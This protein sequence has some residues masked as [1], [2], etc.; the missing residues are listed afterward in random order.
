[1]SESQ[2]AKAPMRVLQEAKRVLLV[3]HGQGTHNRPSWSGSPY[4]TVDPRLTEVGLTQAKALAADA[5]LTGVDLIVVSPLAR[6]VQTAAAA[7]DLEKGA[8]SGARVVLLPLHSERWSAP[9]DE[10]SPKSVLVK[11]F[12]FVTGWEGFEELPEH[13][14]PTS[15]TDADWR[16]VRVPAFLAWLRARPEKR[17][18]VVGHGAFF[19]VKQLLGTHLRNCE[20]AELKL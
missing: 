6:A 12:P 17:I 1:M 13:W 7:F 4:Q 3:R 14:T 16:T 8:P 11:A 10:G 2:E 20:V 18:C 15:S 19:A 9:C 5:R